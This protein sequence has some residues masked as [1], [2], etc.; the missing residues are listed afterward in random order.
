MIAAK[1][2]R[3]KTNYPGVSV[4]RPPIIIMDTRARPKEERRERRNRGD[5]YFA[6]ATGIRTHILPA[7][8]E[9]F[10]HHRR[11][12]A[13]RELARSLALTGPTTGP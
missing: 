11:I 12:A 5:T 6:L 1:D 7:R 3:S 13:T 8:G 4:S 2:R 10:E 9:P